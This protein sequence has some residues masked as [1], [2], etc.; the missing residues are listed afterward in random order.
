MNYTAC[1]K[2]PSGLIDIIL[3]FKAITVSIDARHYLQA[4][5]YFKMWFTKTEKFKTQSNCSCHG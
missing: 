1:C 2:I 4:I 5:R 3:K